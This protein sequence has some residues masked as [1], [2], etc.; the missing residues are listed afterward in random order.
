VLALFLY[1][2]WMLVLPIQ[3]YLCDYIDVLDMLD[4]TASEEP[5]ASFRIYSGYIICAVLTSLC[6]CCLVVPTNHSINVL[7]MCSM[8][9]MCLWPYAKCSYLYS[10]YGILFSRD[11]VIYVYRDASWFLFL[12]S[13]RLCYIWAQVLMQYTTSC[14]GVSSNLCLV[15][16]KFFSCSLIYIYRF[17]D[18]SLM[19][20]LWWWGLCRLL[21]SSTTWE[22]LYTWKHFAGYLGV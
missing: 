12:W 21:W 4:L 22:I 18:G 10:L 11:A 1:M 5:P 6:L 19:L 9:C 7:M 13:F 14:I 20:G 17:H 8:I 15:S 3:W 16:I 2:I